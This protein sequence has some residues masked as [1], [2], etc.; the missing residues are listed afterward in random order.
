VSVNI[1]ALE[2]RSRGFLDGV[3]SILD[4]TGLAPGLAPRLLELEWTESVLMESIEST[5]VVLSGLKAM[6]LRLAVDDSGTGYSSLSYLMQFPIDA[7]K[8]DQSFC[9]RDRARRRRVSHHQGC[10]QHGAESQ[11]AG[12]C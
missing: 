8:V 2:L 10:H 7:L 3:R 11:S 4:D 6:G 1:F 9:T 5:A 12:H